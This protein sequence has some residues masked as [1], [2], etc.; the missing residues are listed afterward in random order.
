MM[1]YI[2]K[3]TGGIKPLYIV[4]SDDSSNHISHM[5]LGAMCLLPDLPNQGTS[6][7]CMIGYFSITSSQVTASASVIPFHLSHLSNCF[8]TMCCPIGVQRLSV[9]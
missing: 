4:G 3:S 6:S 2:N 5:F 1:L 8:R 9:V 7:A